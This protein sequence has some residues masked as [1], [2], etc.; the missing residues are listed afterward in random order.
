MQKSKSELA[1]SA[2]FYI[3]IIYFTLK[4]WDRSQKEFEWVL[5]NSKDPKLD[6]QA[7]AYI[8]NI[9]LQKQ[10][11]KLLKYRNDISL[12]FGYMYDSNILLTSNS[13]GSS[14]GSGVQGSR[15]LAGASYGYRAIYNKENSLSFNYDTYYVYSENQSASAAD[16][17]LNTITIP[18]NFA[19][20]LWGK[21]WS[22]TV[23]PGYEALFMEDSGGSSAGSGVREN[24][25]NSYY[26][27]LKALNTNNP[28]WF[29]SYSLDIRQDD[30][31]LSTSTGDEDQDALKV[32]LTSDQS[33]FF[34]SAKKEGIVANV[35]LISNNAVG[36]N[37]RYNKINLGATYVGAL[38]SW[39]ASWSTG[40]TLYQSSYDSTDGRIDIN[41]T[42]SASLTKPWTKAWSSSLVFSA[43][44][45]NSTVAA[46]SYD[47][48]AVT[49]TGTYK[50]AF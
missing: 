50:G 23:T 16:P 27:T 22:F 11:A 32:S 37:K 43:S 28:S 42:L 46:N 6:K 30:S 31:S 14:S 33:F 47:R 40:L 7:E 29:S 38:S 39:E 49:L 19:V 45:N 18:Y 13:T 3:G 26:A 21:A 9:A 36:K 25:L 10:Y 4:K 41:A 17:F 35:G 12:T 5:D 2:S 24:I 48:N 20:E 44:S 1:P 8:E 15:Y 34:D